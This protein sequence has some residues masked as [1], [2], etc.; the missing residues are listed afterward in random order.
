[1]CICHQQRCMAQETDISID[2]E[3]IS[4]LLER[5]H[6][7]NPRVHQCL[8]GS[9]PL[10]W[11]F[12]QQTLDKI[13]RIVALVQPLIALE[14]QSTFA[15]GSSNVIVGLAVERRETAQ[16]DISHDSDGPNVG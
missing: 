12:S 5:H 1:M 7:S 11:I 4:S 13:H 15:C 14:M 6:L 16:K 2:D 8:P 10:S 9:G 3:L